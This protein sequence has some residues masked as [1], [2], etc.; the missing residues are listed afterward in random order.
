MSLSS[1]GT[2]TL[3]LRLEKLHIKVCAPTVLRLEQFT[4]HSNDTNC[5]RAFLNSDTFY[6]DH[7]YKKIP[8][9]SDHYNYNTN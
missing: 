4:H 5:H 6:S 2:T 3:L 9:H 1:H 7:Y 8:N